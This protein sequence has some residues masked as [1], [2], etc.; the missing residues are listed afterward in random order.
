[1]LLASSPLHLRV[2]RVRVLGAIDDDARCRSL[3]VSRY[4][5]VAESVS[6]AHWLGRDSHEF[7]R[8]HLDNNKISYS[9]I[10][11]ILASKACVSSTIHV[12]MYSNRGSS[13]QLRCDRLS[14]S[15]RGMTRPELAFRPKT[16]RSSAGRSSQS[17]RK[18]TRT[19][20]TSR[21]AVSLKFSLKA[22]GLSLSSVLESRSLHSL[23]VRLVELYCLRSQR[24][25]EKDA[26]PIT[27]SN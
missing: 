10:Y 18:G 12:S 19:A 22:S 5:T 16:R 14:M 23:V 27:L 13:L 1:M 9:G 21:A 17:E 25:L 3:E 7:D 24:A 15:P 4:V 2:R 26:T 8:S 6:V 20:V 11:A